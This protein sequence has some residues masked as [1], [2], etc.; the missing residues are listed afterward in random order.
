MVDAALED[1]APMTMSGDLYA[2][3]SY[4]IIDKL[5]V[6]RHKPV[7]TFLNDVVPVKIFD[8]SHDVKRQSSND[9]NNLIIIPGV[10]LTLGGQEINHLLNGSSSV[11]VQRDGDEVS[12]HG[13]TYEIPLL[14]CGV[15][16][17]LLAQIIA[18]RIGHQVGEVVK[19]LPEDDVPVFLDPF[20]EL[21]LQEAAAMLIFAHR[22]DLA[23]QVF[24]PAAGIAVVFAI[25][26]PPFML[27]TT[28]ESVHFPFVAEATTAA[29]HDTVAARIGARL[30]HAA[31]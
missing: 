15:F 22:W 6:F 18:E 29:S 3:R 24:E 10:G 9:R 2:V 25:N 26:V 21:L 28:V 16:K 27:C 19:S 23:D 4:S 14:I 12:C 13:F 1:A 30:I 11:H 31:A 8:K 20:F 7:E 17:Q 5:V